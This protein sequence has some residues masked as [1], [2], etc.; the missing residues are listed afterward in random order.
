MTCYKS[1]LSNQPNTSLPTTNQNEDVIHTANEMSQLPVYLS[2]PL[3]SRDFS[4]A[5]PQ[6][7]LVC[8]A[9]TSGVIGCDTFR[10]Q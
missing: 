8:Y 10:L 3:D 2:L 7:W 1:R 6:F 9:V 4:R 5:F